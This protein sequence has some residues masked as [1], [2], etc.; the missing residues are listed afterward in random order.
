MELDRDVALLDVGD[1]FVAAV[2]AEDYER[3]SAFLWRVRPDG[4]AQCSQGDGRGRTLHEL[5]HRFVMRAR[6]D[7]LVDHENGIRLDCRK[8]NLRVTTPQ[9]N[10]WNRA[11]KEGKTWKGIYP[12]GRKWKAR[13][14]ID[15]QSVYLGLYDTAEIAARAYDEAARRLFGIYARLNFP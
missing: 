2:D 13:I 1:G 6:P 4:Y 3:V 14:K 10:A 5:L 11:P 9:Q 12:H 7:E 15:G 8:E